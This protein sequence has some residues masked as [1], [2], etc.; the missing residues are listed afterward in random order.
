MINLTDEEAER[1]V[2]HFDDLKLE[3]RELKKALEAFID[4]RG[5]NGK[6]LEPLFDRAYIKASKLLGRPTIDDIDGNRLKALRTGHSMTQ[7][8]LA[9]RMGVTRTMIRHWEK[10]ERELNLERKKQVAEI[11]KED[12]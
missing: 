12:E 4:C 1:T 7:D 9:E 11:F 8:E 5:L 3:N 10:D 2:Q 6:P